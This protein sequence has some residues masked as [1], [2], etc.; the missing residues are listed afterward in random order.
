MDLIDTGE[1]A[2]ML[3]VSRSYATDKLTKRVDF[4]SPKINLSNK[5]RRWDKA[6]VLAWA[7]SRLA[8]SSADSR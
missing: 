4:P 7:Q 6:E 8:M 5:F 1:I 2:A 3:K